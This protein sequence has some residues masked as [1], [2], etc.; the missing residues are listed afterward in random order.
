MGMAGSILRE[1]GLHCWQ[2][3]FE[4]YN[5]LIRLEGWC[6][7]FAMLLLFIQSLS[8][9]QL[10]ATPWAAACQA[11]L[12]FTISQSLPKFMSIDSV[13]PSSHLILCCPL[14]LPPSIF[15]TIKFF[16]KE[17]AL[18]IRWPKNW[19]FSFS[20]SPLHGPVLFAD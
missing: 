10:L 17:F 9:V 15:P 2:I 20:S 19:S 5:L 1:V 11:S 18:H 6:F 3:V 16:S 13:M 8:H 7:H 12:S 14:L 4:C